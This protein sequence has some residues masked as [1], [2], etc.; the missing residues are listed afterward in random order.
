M[1]LNVLNNNVSALNSNWFMLE[2]PR[3]NS[4]HATKADISSI[5]KTVWLSSRKIGFSQFHSQERMLL[6]TFMREKE[7][8]MSWKSLQ[9]S[10]NSCVYVT[11]CRRESSESPQKEQRKKLLHLLKLAKGTQRERV[12]F[13]MKPLY[14]WDTEEYFP[15]FSFIPKH[16]EFNL[17][18]EKLARLE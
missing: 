8:K 1:T 13:F 4:N 6:S 5:P 7:G 11:L 9:I 17:T 10:E 15:I 3:Q 18:L 16:S 14:A 12:S 2:K